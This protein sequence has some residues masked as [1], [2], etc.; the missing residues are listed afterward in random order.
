[1]E[2][3]SL[4]EID[5]RIEQ[6]LDLS[7]SVD[8]E[9][10]ELLATVDD[11]DALAVSKHDKLEAC[12]CW[13]KSQQALVDAIKEEQRNLMARRK[14]AEAAI[15]RMKVYVADHMD[16]K[17]FETPKVRMQKRRSTKVDVYDPDSV[18]DE[19]QK[20]EVSVTFDKRKMA[21]DMKGGVGVPG[22]ALETSDTL[23]I[24]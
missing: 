15:E 1:M 20:V 23:S 5:R 18:P 24:K 10:G 22:A 12:G 14:H 9:T 21:K 16:S 11:L 7:F 8:D 6:I 17:T 19:Y 3:L 4:Y 13:I 2:G